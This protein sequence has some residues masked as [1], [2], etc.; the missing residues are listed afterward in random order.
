MMESNERRQARRRAA[1][2]DARRAREAR[3]CRDAG[4]EEEVVAEEAPAVS[5]PGDSHDFSGPLDL[6]DGPEEEPDSSFPDY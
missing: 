3:A 2:E 5:G 6:S 4:G 1:E